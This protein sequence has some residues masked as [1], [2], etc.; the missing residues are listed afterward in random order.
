MPLGALFARPMPLVSAKTF[1]SFEF[2]SNSPYVLDLAGDWRFRW[3]G[4][5]ARAP[6]GFQNPAYDVSRWETV[7]VPSCSEALGWGARDLPCRS[8]SCYRRSFALPQAWAGRRTYLEMSG[9]CGDSTVW[10]NGKEFA[11]ETNGVYDVTTA[12]EPQAM[13]EI[14]VR[15]VRGAGAGWSGLCGSVRL[16]A[17]PKIELRDFSVSVKPDADYLSAEVEVVAEVLKREDSVSVGGI[18]GIADFV[19]KVFDE[20]GLEVASTPIE[21]VRLSTG[22]A[23]TTVRRKMTVDAPRFWSAE[24]P[25]FYTVAVQVDHDLRARRTAFRDAR[26]RDRAV[27]RAIRVSAADFAGGAAASEEEL[28]ACLGALKQANFNA[29]VDGGDL[30]V[31][32]VELCDRYGFYVIANAVPDLMAYGKL[33]AAG[34]SSF[35][36]AKQAN[37]PLGVVCANAATGRAVLK[38]AHTAIAASEYLARWNLTQDGIE[39]AGGT[40]ELPPIPAGQR[41]LL[42]LPLPVQSNSDVTVSG[43][44]F[45][46]ISFVTRTAAPGVKAGHEAVHFQIP[47]A[48]GSAK[49]DEPV[50]DDGAQ[51]DIRTSADTKVLEVRAGPTRAEFDCEGRRFRSLT[52]NGRTFRADGANGCWFFAD[53]LRGLRVRPGDLRVE[54]NAVVVTDELLSEGPAGYDRTVRW[55]FAADGKVR[56]EVKLA[57]FGQLSGGPGA[58]GFAWS[59]DDRAGLKFSY[60]GRG[61]WANR[62]DACAAAPVGRYAGAGTELEGMRSDVRRFAVVGKDGAG[63]EIGAATPFALEFSPVVRMR[64][65]SPGAGLRA[66]NWTLV[67]TPVG[68]AAGG[69]A[70]KDSSWWFF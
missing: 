14:A 58:L 37:S 60:L 10:V 28:A 56:V 27:L 13:N 1:D 5:Q 50:A 49:A 65:S 51:V 38:N 46:N 41:G 15:V 63:V 18:R 2:E 40:F 29:V 26:Q 17:A 8:V 6:E 24:R 25:C 44:C 53:G 55:S 4:S 30:P 68:G 20:K 66:E 7:S 45:Y 43:E 67:L 39:V 42:E 57:P 19:A 61:P 54:G 32:F 69:P 47:Y 21:Q 12:V 52:V 35:E 59:P 22:G 11:L 23:L 70:E 31:R 9:V 62:P 3:S 16:Y 48:I 36:E 33:G 64:L 34:T